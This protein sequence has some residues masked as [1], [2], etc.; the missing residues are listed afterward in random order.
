MNAARAV[1]RVMADRGRPPGRLSGGAPLLGEL[2]DRAGLSSAYSA[3][4]P[5]T[6]E[7][8]SGQGR[9]PVHPDGGGAWPAGRPATAVL[10]LRPGERGHQSRA[11]RT[12]PGLCETTAMP[13]TPGG[14]RAGR[15]VAGWAQGSS[16]GGGDPTSVPSCG[17]GTPTGSATRCPLP[18]PPAMYS[19]SS[20][21][22]AV[23]P[24]WSTPSR[25]CAAPAS[26]AFRLPA[27]SPTRSG[28]RCAGQGRPAGLAEPGLHRRGAGPGRRCC[29][30][31]LLHVGRPHRAQVGA[32]SCGSPSTGRARSSRKGSQVALCAGHSS[33]ESN[34]RVWPSR[35]IVNDR[36]QLGEYRSSARPRRQFCPGGRSTPGPWRGYT[37][38]RL[39]ADRD[40]NAPRIFPGVKVASQGDVWS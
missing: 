31:R 8:A 20:C 6:G 35:V 4:V 38:Q 21:A 24:G 19:P 23:T 11:P 12:G 27:W 9:D 26:T 33:S 18:T 13:A 32:W 22:S 30:Y 1:E 36:G 3:A 14:G 34:H 40:P 25:R 7:R 16:A 15:G 39:P 29:A 2:T 5:W 28:S 10:R 17:C 37:G